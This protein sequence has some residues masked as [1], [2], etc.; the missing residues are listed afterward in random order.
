M[1][2]LRHSSA[3]IIIA[4]AL[5]GACQP[6]PPAA[7]VANDRA[8]IETVAADTTSS[9]T[10]PVLTANGWGDLRIGMTRAQVVAAAGEDGNPNAVGGPEPD[11]CDQFRPTRAPAGMLV[12]IE[13]GRLTRITVSRSAQV[14]TDRG[15]RVGDSASAIKAAYGSDAEVTPHKYEDAPAE[16]ITVWT[17]KPPAPA[18][19]G[20]V[21]EIGGEGRVQ[22]IHAG[23]ASIQYVE[24]CL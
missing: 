21:Y 5:A 11:Q 6:Q 7:E 24:G 3:R 18:A 12:M 4:A 15:F 22:H 16:Y 2:E 19:R 8:V 13:Q 9:H 17:T 1:M 14:K 20:I 10:V 23:S